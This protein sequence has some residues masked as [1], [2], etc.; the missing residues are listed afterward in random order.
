MSRQTI[1]LA[2]L[3]GLFMTVVALWMLVNEAGLSA[4]IEALVQDRPATL[5]LSLMCLGS[6]LAVVLGHQIWSGGIAPV[7]VTLLGW[8]LL[9][10]GVALL[11]LPPNLIE[12][13]VNA[14]SGPAWLYPVGVVALAL[15]LILTYAGFRSPPIVFGKQ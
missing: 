7:L 10:R 5:L 12:A 14:V 4:I 11:F 15:G 3:F 2:R 8:L 13:L 1:F 9:I 6:G